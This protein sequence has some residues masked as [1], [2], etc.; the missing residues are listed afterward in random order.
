[1]K[2]IL[3]LLLL[4]GV[5]GGLGIAPA[6]AAPA[7]GPDAAEPDVIEP[8][9]AEA[10]AD[11]RMQWFNEAR[12][13]VF[14]HWGIY[15]VDGVDESWSFYRGVMPHDEYMKQLQGFTAKNYDPQAWAELIARSGARYAVLTT[16]H[17]DGVALWNS[18]QGIN[19]V[20]DTPAKRDLVGP[21][22][23]ALRKNDLKVGLYYSPAD[24]SHPDYDVF[25]AFQ[26]R[27]DIAQDPARWQRFLDYYQGQ[28]KD[29]AQRY[30]PDLYWFDDGGA[31][32]S[33]KEMQTRKV[34][35]MLLANNPDAI[36]N[37]RQ[38]GEGDYG[39]PEQAVPILPPKEKYWELC[40]TMNDSWG[41][42]PHDRN[43]K[44]PN[45]VIRMLVDT[46]SMGGNLLLNIGPRADGTIPE[47]QVRILE[48]TGRWT[49]KHQVAVYGTEAGIPKDYYYGPSAL[50][51]D[52]TVLML[53]LDGKPNGPLMIKGLKNK[54][55][56]ARVIGSGARVRTWRVGEPELPDAAPGLLYVDVPKDA[57]DPQVTVIGLQL[58]GPVDLFEPAK[59]TDQLNGPKTAPH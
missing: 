47:E 24:W 3:A 53:Y 19:V 15:A 8:I 4:A 56:G 50:A 5:G 35:Q 34:R 16:R 30:N 26:K 9:A 44:T 29:L 43:Y 33:A 23:D 14:I 49:A 41:Y 28:V 7:T 25:T 10:T 46:I 55:I 27:Y 17:H 2:N 13:G 12:F 36:V 11:T 20:R 40:Q 58:D 51:A 6:A 38:P 48:E 45:Q 22:V 39:T 42:Q 18:K 37:S 32:H 1:M 54:V 59:Q 57:L 52:G 31:E 21:F